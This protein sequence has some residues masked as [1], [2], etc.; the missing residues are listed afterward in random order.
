[1]IENEKEQLKIK[2]STFGGDRIIILEGYRNKDGKKRIT[3]TK[4]LAQIYKLENKIKKNTTIKLGLHNSRKIKNKDDD[5]FVVYQNH[6]TFL[7]GMSDEDIINLI[8][9]NNY[10]KVMKTKNE[11]KLALL[12]YFY[13]KSNSI[14]YLINNYS[15]GAE[16][17]TLNYTNY[18]DENGEERGGD[19][20]YLCRI[21]ELDYKLEPGSI[22][23]KFGK[24]E[25][26]EPIF[27]IHKNDE[28]IEKIKIKDIINLLKSD[29]Y[30]KAI[31]NYRLIFNERKD[32][33]ELSL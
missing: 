9:S 20:E 3:N 5:R 11:P 26:E 1:M 21:Y 4:E 7:T 18:Y 30:E 2:E 16:K 31:D 27:Q 15:G 22:S 28:F 19:Y 33:M 25:N 29:N 8:K 13:Y 12:G 23:I 24:Q 6:T 14:L 10:K 17:T 32:E